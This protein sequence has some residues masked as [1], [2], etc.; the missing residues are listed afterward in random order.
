VRQFADLD[1]G[2]LWRMM[3]QMRHHSAADIMPGI[4][5]PVLVLAGQRDT[6]TP[7]SVQRKMQDLLPDSELVVFENGGHLLPVEEADGVAAALIDWLERR[8]DPQRQR[9][10][11]RPRR[12]PRARVGASP[13]RGRPTSS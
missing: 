11:S 8:V 12:S 13:G 9:G 5:V 2:V 7:M 4:T 6:F 3:V 1:L 10:T